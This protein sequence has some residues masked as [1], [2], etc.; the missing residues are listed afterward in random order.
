M[1]NAGK[2]VLAIVIIAALLFGFAKLIQLSNNVGPTVADTHEEYSGIVPH[3]EKISHNTENACWS[4]YID[5]TTNS[6]YL[7]YSAGHQCAMSVV[8]NEDGTPMT[9]EQLINTR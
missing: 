7:V 9:P 5:H 6:V 4:Y 2:V 1:R 3:M 8:L